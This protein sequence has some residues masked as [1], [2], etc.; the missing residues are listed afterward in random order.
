MK[1]NILIMIGKCGNR[2]PQGVYRSLKD[3]LREKHDCMCVDIDSGWKLLQAILRIM[4]GFAGCAIVIHSNG[5]RVPLIMML[6]SKVDIKNKYYCVMHGIA[7]IEKKFRYI[8]DRDIKRERFVFSNYDNIVCVSDFQKCNLIRLYGERSSVFIIGNGVDADLITSRREPKRLC[9]KNKVT[10]MFAGGFERVKGLDLAIR[11]CGVLETYGF[12]TEVIVY[13][14]KNESSGCVMQ[15]CL[16]EAECMGVHLDYRGETSDRN[17]LADAYRDSMFC[18]AISRFDTFNNTVLEAMAVGCIPV[19]SNKCGISGLLDQS[20]A[21]LVNLNQ[22]Q[23]YIKAADVI[24]DLLRTGKIK[25]MSSNAAAFAE[26][27]T[28]GDVAERYLNLRGSKA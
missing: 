18:F 1:R 26:A 12:S 11:V 20:T 5:Y 17:E 16:D 9:G 14:R 23:F 2:G 27:N 4:F 28:W 7:S 21:I 10:F 15:E 6:I 13:G 8:S 3:A 25:E 22:P 24:R 19:V